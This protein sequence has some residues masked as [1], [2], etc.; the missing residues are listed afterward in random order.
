MS[1]AFPGNSASTKQM[2]LIRLNSTQEDDGRIR[3]KRNLQRGAII[4][5]AR[6][7]PDRQKPDINIRVM[8]V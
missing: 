7:R 2:M 4:C 6:S 5:S 3:M 1:L 8:K